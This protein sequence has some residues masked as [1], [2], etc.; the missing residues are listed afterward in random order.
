MRRGFFV[1][2]LISVFYLFMLASI[3]GAEK[4]KIAYLVSSFSPNDVPAE[5]E[6]LTEVNPQYSREWVVTTIHETYDQTGGKVTLNFDY[7]FSSDTGVYYYTNRVMFKAA[8]TDPPNEPPDTVFMEMVNVSYPW[9]F[10]VDAGNIMHEIFGLSTCWEFPHFTWNDDGDGLFGPGDVLSVLND[11]SDP[12]LS[13][14]LDILEVNTGWYISSAESVPSMSDWGLIVTVMI[15]ITL[16][17][18]IVFRR[19]RC[20]EN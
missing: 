20:A 10:V 2:I 5:G 12:P 13:K 15:M 19:Y 17:V 18:W 3:A 16:T 11:E 7:P 14:T 1:T 4:P 9:N 6:I 8:V